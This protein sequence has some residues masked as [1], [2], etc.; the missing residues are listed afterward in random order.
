MYNEHQFSV[1]NSSP[2]SHWSNIFPVLGL[3]SVKMVQKS[4]KVTSDADMSR[5]NI[6][7]NIILDMT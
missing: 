1:N 5:H 6:I 4:C 2:E 3:P 7:Y